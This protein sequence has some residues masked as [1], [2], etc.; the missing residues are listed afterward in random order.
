MWNGEFEA[1]GQSRLTIVMP[2]T[3][4][5]PVG[6]DHQ[7]DP[8]Q[9]PHANSIGRLGLLRIL[10]L[11]GFLPEFPDRE[12]ATLED[13][14]KALSEIFPDDYRNLVRGAY[15]EALAISKEDFGNWCDGNDYSRPSFWF[16]D[17]VSGDS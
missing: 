10:E 3:A 2:G 12:D 6:P 15:L 14:F 13:S 17:E 7:Q 9:S 11:L 16:A 4:P 5:P 1:G 8:R